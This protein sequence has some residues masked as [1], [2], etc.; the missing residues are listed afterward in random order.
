MSPARPGSTDGHDSFR[1]GGIAFH[2]PTDATVGSISPP[3]TIPEMTEAQRLRWRSGI[4]DIV[5]YGNSEAVIPSGGSEVTIGRGVV[6][7]DKG[8]IV[9][10]LAGGWEHGINDWKIDAKFDDGSRVP[11]KIAEDERH[12]ILVLQPVGGVDINYFFRLATT[13]YRAGDE[14]Y[15]GTNDMS[16]P[17]HR[18]AID[19][20]RVILTDRS[21]ATADSPVWQL[22]EQ[23]SA[24]LLG[25]QPV[26]SATG[27]LLGITL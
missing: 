21:T 9:T 23:P 7:S 12:G 13:L 5:V 27:E 3:I 24:D 1:A 25:G 8:L 4:V 26:M 20:S 22:E 18:F 2:K 14:V 19:K 6:V 10:H 15:V 16:S 17:E 11:L